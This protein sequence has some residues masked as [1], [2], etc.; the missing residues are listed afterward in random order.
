MEN[1][2]TYIPGSEW[3]YFKI[4][5]GIKTA[6][7]ILMKNLYPLALELLENRVID[8]WFYIRY[9]DPDFH[10]R[11]RI[12]LT[13]SQDF[14]F[15]FNG[16]YKTFYSLIDNDLVWNIQCDTYQRELERYGANTI[17]LIEHIFFIDSELSMKLLGCLNP[18]NAEE[19]RWNISLLLID[20]YFSIFSLDMNRRKQ[21]MNQMAEGYKNEF[22]IKHHNMKRQLDTKYRKYKELI[23]SVMDINNVTDSIY[24]KYRKLIIQYRQIIL[25]DI[26]EIIRMEKEENLQIKSDALLTSIIH[27]AMNRWFRSKNRLH[28]LVIYDF[29]TRY[30]DSYIAKRKYT[31]KE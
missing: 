10:I 21:L 24:D 13:K 8:R 3:L 2:R 1:I 19:H 12:H 27:M 25:P 29:M 30:Y 20:S 9:A 7:M 5:T 26:H 4:Y 22:G 23:Y 31:Q 15:V 28:E 6:D 14:N 16:F 11:F 17:N 18:E